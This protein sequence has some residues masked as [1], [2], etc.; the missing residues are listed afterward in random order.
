MLSTAFFANISKTMVER[1]LYIQGEIV[2]NYAL[3]NISKTHQNERECDSSTV[4]LN[5]YLRIIKFNIKYIYIFIYFYTKLLINI[6][7]NRIVYE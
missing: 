1:Q 6:L 7:I 3:E 5:K 2:Q 4:S